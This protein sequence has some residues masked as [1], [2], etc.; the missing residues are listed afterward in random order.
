MSLKAFP[1][2]RGGDPYIVNK[3]PDDDFFSPHTRG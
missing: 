1:R 2:I 3:K